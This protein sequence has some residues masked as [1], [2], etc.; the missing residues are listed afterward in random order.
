MNGTLFFFLDQVTLLF[1]FIWFFFS[2]IK[3]MRREERMV[4]TERAR[5]R[6]RDRET[7]SSLL[8]MAERK[9]N[10]VFNIVCSHYNRG[11]LGNLGNIGWR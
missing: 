4:E 3:G 11:T 7:G 1:S 9:R 8:R 2:E 10:F 5:E 6:E